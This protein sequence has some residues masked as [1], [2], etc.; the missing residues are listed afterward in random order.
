MEL[1]FVTCIVCTRLCTLLC[2]LFRDCVRVHCLMALCTVMYTA[3]R[4]LDVWQN[5]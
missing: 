5:V 4:Q 2:K 3:L 1:F